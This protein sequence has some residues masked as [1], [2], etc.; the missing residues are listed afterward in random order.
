MSAYRVIDTDAHYLE[1]IPKIAEYVDEPWRS[2]LTSDGETEGDAPADIYPSSSGDRAVFGRIRRD[3]INW[4][5]VSTPEE[6]PAIMAH[7]GVDATIVIS[8]VVLSFARIQGADERPVVLAE[9]FTEYML[10]EVLDPGAGIYTMVPIPYQDPHVAVE[11]LD[12]VGD[13]PGIVAGLMVTAGAEPPLGH[14]RYDPI[15][16]KAEELGLPIV[17]HAGGGGLDQYYLSGYEKFIETHTLG[18]LNANMAQ[19]T[20]LIV[21]GTPVK[22]P[23]LEIVFQESGIFWIPMMMHRLDSEYLKRQSEAPLLEQRPSKYIKEFHFGIQPLEVP[24]NEDHLAHVI[25][26]L[27]GPDRLMYASDYPHWDYDLPQVITDRP[28]LSDTEKQR[29]LADNAAEVFGI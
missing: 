3:D 7:L 24:E 26:M 10:E 1:A 22:F 6:L 11:L 15:Y 13:E 4:P 9:G 20:S 25:E 28:C 27:G 21:Q 8:Q 2:R 29:I 19:L 17:F 18:F 16:A 14:R 5:D 12:R 23:D